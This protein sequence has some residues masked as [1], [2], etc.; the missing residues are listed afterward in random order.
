MM[1]Y[2][3]SALLAIG[4]I[5]LSVL[6]LL[7][8]SMGK[9]LGQALELPPYY[10]LYNAA[11]FLLLFPIP[12]I[13]ILTAIKAWGLPDSDADVITLIKIGVF[14]FPMAIAFTLAVYATSKYWAWIWE[15]LRRP[16]DEGGS[17][18]EA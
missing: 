9:R 3:S 1:D 7:F 16:K 12:L 15:E 2:L 4:P 10:R 14:S 11:L 5:S 13:W 6:L 18:D 8:M 17:E